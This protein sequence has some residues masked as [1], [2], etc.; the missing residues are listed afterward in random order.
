MI[1]K[2][3]NKTGNKITCLLAVMLGVKSSKNLHSWFSCLFCSRIGQENAAVYRRYP[4]EA[5]ATA[6]SKLL[7]AKS[8]TFVT[9]YQYLGTRATS[10][11]GRQRY[12]ILR[13]CLQ[14]ICSG[15][16]PHVNGGLLG[17]FFALKW[18][19]RTPF[20]LKTERRTDKQEIEA[21]LS[22]L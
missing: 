11:P 16:L 20:A 15:Q 9:F 6:A 19:N 13:W 14:S 18:E 17:Q 2:S 3:C 5:H 8:S 10:L 4:K 7:F 22:C 21:Y 1:C 12:V